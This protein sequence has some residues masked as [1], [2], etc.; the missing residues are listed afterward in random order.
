MIPRLILI[1]GLALLVTLT[2][3]VAAPGLDARPPNPTC[4]APTRATGAG[5]VSADWLNSDVGSV[6]AAGS[7]TRSGTSF[8]VRGSGADIWGTADEFRFAQRLLTG[9]GDLIARVTSLTNT[10]PWAKAGLMIRESLAPGSRYALVMMTPG[11]NG[12]SFHYRTAT[13]GSAAPPN[14]AD[15]VTALPRWLKVSR[16][17]NV[18]TG[19][20]SADGL[21]WTMRGSVTLALPATVYT[22]L[23]VTS[24][25]DGTLATGAFASVQVVPG[26]GTVSA[27]GAVTAEDAFPTTPAFTQPTKALQAPGSADRWYVLEKTGRV[28]TFYAS[29]P[30]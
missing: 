14:S 17:G 23:A 15:K 20:L 9:D 7:V 22:G 25:N 29:K 11:S 2:G 8:T 27:Q 6:A 19:Y 13:G 18:V 10:D 4:L 3:A 5:S 12:A 28:K 16:R 24:H 21:S 1:A 30:A 26:A